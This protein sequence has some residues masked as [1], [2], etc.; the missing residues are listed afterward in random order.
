MC[1]IPGM[2]EALEAGRQ[3]Y[4]EKAKTFHPVC[5]SLLNA[6]WD[7]VTPCPSQKELKELCKKYNISSEFEE[8]EEFEER[9]VKV[10]KHEQNE[11]TYKKYESESLSVLS[12]TLQHWIVAGQA[13]LSMEFSRP[14]YWSE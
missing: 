10:L 1:C 7:L 6:G 14:E 3:E 2:E 4:F 12:D 8:E 9:R 13:P 5:A 11:T